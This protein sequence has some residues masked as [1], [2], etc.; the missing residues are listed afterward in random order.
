MHELL[1]HHCKDFLSASVIEDISNYMD[2]VEQQSLRFVPWK[3]YNY[4]PSV[5]F[6]IAYA[7]DAIFLKFY[8]VE[9]S[10]RAAVS[11]INGPVSEDSCVEF[12]ISFDETGYYNLEFNCIGTALVGFGKD[13]NHRA[14]IPES[15]VR[16]IRI[17]SQIS[18]MGHE[19]SW[20]LTVVLPFTVF[21]FHPLKS[22]DGKSHRGNFFKCGDSLPQPHFLSWSDI[23]APQPDFHLP[24]FFGKLD[25]TRG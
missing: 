3:T 12:F 7:E 6:S 4:K 2:R 15:F 22:L 1:V 18:S 14:L 5:H 20:Q 16:N 17:L 11:K 21:L 8:V 10:I 24:C 9:S 13:R 19:I 25:F 23:E